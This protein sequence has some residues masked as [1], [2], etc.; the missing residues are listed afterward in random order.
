MSRRVLSLLLSL[1]ALFS[2]APLA[3]A[4]GPSSIQPI[5]VF[6]NSP[7]LPFQEYA[8]GRIGIVQSGFGRKTLFIAYRYLNGGSFPS[9]EQ[10]ALVEALRG[11]A[12][13]DDGGKALKAWIAARTEI[14]SSEEKLPEIYTER[15]FGGYDFFPN[16]TGNAF[17]VATETLKNRAATYG[18]EDLNVRAWLA[19]QD[20]VF[21]NCHGTGMIPAELGPESAGWLRKDR[22]YQ[23]GA[24]L[25]YSLNFDAARERFAKIANDVDSSWHE[26]ADY[27]IG[28]TLVRQASLSGDDKTKRELYGRAENHLQLISARQGR[29]SKAAQKLVALI[30]YRERPEERVRE[31]AGI[32]ANQSGEDNLKQDLIDYV[33]LLDKFEDRILKEEERKRKEETAGATSPEKTSDYLPNKEATL[34]YEAVQRGEKIQ[35]NFTPILADGSQ[36]YRN[37]IFLYFKFDA[38]E[39]EVLQEVEAKLNRQLTPAESKELHAQFVLALDSRKYQVSP[40]RKFESGVLSGHEGCDYECERLTLNLVPDFLRADDL[41]D[42]IFSLQTEDPKA[43]DYAVAKWRDTESPA[44]LVIALAKADKNSPGVGRLTRQAA[45]VDRDSPAFPTVAYHLIRLAIAAGR[46]TEARKLLDEIISSDSGLPASARNQFL[47]QRMRLSENMTEFLKFAQ[48]KPVAFSDEGGLGTMSDLFGAA[49][50]RWDSRYYEESQE[51]YE[52]QTDAIY[53]ELL[54]WDDRLAFDYTT[55]DILNWHFPLV[56]LEQAARDPA[57]PDYLRRRFV[58][59]VW[60]RAVLLRN[61]EVA[62]RISPEVIKVAPEM[63]P[64]LK[65]Y[66]DAQ[67]SAER[68]HAALFVLLHFPS[69]SPFVAGGIP[70]FATAEK[71][72]YYF[73]SS[74]WCTP[75][76]TEYDNQGEEVR[77]IV[78]SPV[79]LTTDELAAAHRERS[80]LVEIGN[81]KSYLGQK[82]IQ[83]AKL[84]PRDPR[85]PRIPEALFIALKANETYKYGCT[86]WETNQEIQQEADSIL[87]RSYSTSPWTARLSQ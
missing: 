87:R 64:L 51:E 41:S 35:I 32:L 67:T 38:A 12:P 20:V 77:K 43:Y 13:E 44:W 45:K 9:D 8:R 31:L 66:L 24:A 60:T 76:D 22:D 69:L 15:R 71:A 28:R 19:A 62:R 65:S 82:V 47:E 63:Q 61:E 56:T 72:Q 7:D 81:G 37:F 29:F 14:M 18:L 27:L 36:D 3:E 25:L 83:W 46:K 57:L 5:F 17:E 23:I 10:E 74:W 48:R 55:L 85:D 16:C 2:F 49:R 21:Q 75:S 53:Q 33:W 11:K 30:K 54:L 52:R 86:S 78:P 50:D 39:A 40:N 68:E 26:T 42:W 4:C 73:E 1:T 34:A 79:F 84:A 59:A 80:A 6:K 70:E 58:L